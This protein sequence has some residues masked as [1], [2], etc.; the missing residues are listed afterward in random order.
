M[1][2]MIK[3][4]LSLWKHTAPCKWLTNYKLRPWPKELLY[5]LAAV[6]T[7]AIRH[8][9]NALI[10][11]QR[12]YVPD[13]HLL[14]QRHR[15]PIKHCW[16][17]ATFKCLNM[18]IFEFPS[19]HPGTFWAAST[20]TLQRSQ[21]SKDALNQLQKQAGKYLEDHLEMFTA[22]GSTGHCMELEPESIFGWWSLVCSH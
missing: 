11:S 2:I 12:N 22:V 3:L 4:L 18:P 9:N 5:Y 1:E 21:S 6:D 7:F 10:S 13:K 20:L 16:P 14:H 19:A 17:T 15:S 8:I